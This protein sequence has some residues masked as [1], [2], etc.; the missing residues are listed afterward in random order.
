MMVTGWTCTLPSRVLAMVHW[1]VL[2][3]HSTD[4]LK[5]GRFYLQ[6]GF[7]FIITE[8]ENYFEYY[9]VVRV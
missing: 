9:K 5:I 4:F 1:H 7:P 6:H 3:L 2:R 8:S